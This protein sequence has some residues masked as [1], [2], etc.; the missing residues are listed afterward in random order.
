MKDLRIN[1]LTVSDQV[2]PEQLDGNEGLRQTKGSCQEDADDFTNVGRDQV[3]EDKT[4]LFKF[5]SFKIFL[6]NKIFVSRY[7]VP[8]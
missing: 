8:Y 2:D 7:Q 4:N 1:E 5:I 3:S 6:F